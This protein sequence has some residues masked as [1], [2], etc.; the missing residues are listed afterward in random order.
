MLSLKY[1]YKDWFTLYI[2]C[3]CVKLMRMIPTDA[4]LKNKYIISNFSSSV[5]EPSYNKLNKFVK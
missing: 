3:I 5:S 4:V 1:R 2:F